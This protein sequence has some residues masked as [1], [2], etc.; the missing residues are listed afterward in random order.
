MQKLDST[1]FLSSLVIIE[2]EAHT[3]AC[4]IVMLGWHIR[5]YDAFGTELC[6]GQFF[7]LFSQLSF[8]VCYIGNCE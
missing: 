6:W 5:G 3:F 4:A 2:A 7:S 8:A 1:C